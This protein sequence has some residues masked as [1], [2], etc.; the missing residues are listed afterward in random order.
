[1]TAI[2]PIWKVDSNQLAKQF[3]EHG[4]RSRIICVDSEFLDNEFLGMDF[5]YDFLNKLPESIDKCGENGEFHTFTYNG[6]VFKDEIRHSIGS[7]EYR[8]N[9]FWYCDIIPD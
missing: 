4:F 3:I 7:T 2:F 9:R 1:M 6:P 8:D 5:N